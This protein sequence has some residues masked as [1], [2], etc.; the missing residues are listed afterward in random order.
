MGQ[1]EWDSDFI[2]FPRLIAELEAAGVFSDQAVIEDLCTSMDLTSEDIMEIVGRAS[3][4]FDTI[5][6]NT[7]NGRYQGYA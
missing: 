5:V 7:R 1:R 4:K 6:A 3:D 2:Q